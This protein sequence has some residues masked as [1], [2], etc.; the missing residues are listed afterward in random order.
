MQ[1]WL[2]LGR[3]SR[4]LGWLLLRL[5]VRLE[6]VLLCWGLQLGLMLGLRLRL[7]LVL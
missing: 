4:E 6:A 3:L 2:G 7:R 5:G 1:L